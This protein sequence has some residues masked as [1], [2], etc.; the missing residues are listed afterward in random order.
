MARRLAAYIAILLAALCAG[1]AAAKERPLVVYSPHGPEMLKAA[2]EAFKAVA[3]DVEIDWRF[4]GAEEV[5][6]KLKAE[7]AAA[8]ADLWWGGPHFTFIRGAKDGLLMPYEPSWKGAAPTGAYDEGHLWYADL[9]TP[10][11]I[12]FNKSLVKDTDVPKDWDDLLKPALEGKLVVR[13]PLQSGTMRA[14][15]AALI[16]RQLSKGKSLAQAMAWM[17]RLDAQTARYV[18]HSQAM[19]ATIGKGLM[20]FGFW[21][22]P[23]IVMKT[24]QGY[25]VGFV[26]PASGLPVLHDAIALVKKEKERVHPYA[27]K[28]YELVTAKDF[29]QKLTQ[30]PFNRVPV[31][32]DLGKAA[33]PD[34]M[35][36]SHYKV[37]AVDW[38]RVS[39]HEAAWLAQWEKDVATKEKL[40]H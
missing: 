14:L 1:P 36:D 27:T 19:F 26:Y 7:S 29:A 38:K 20:T 15:Y 18:D 22:L 13:Y 2:Q 4:F 37:M 24:R 8:V 21:N 34:Y 5:Y 25:P 10:I 35:D 32:T 16:D 28:F 11:S 6:D 3:P 23:E 33:R 12:T 30:E 39:E 9:A 40:S 31:R 17:K